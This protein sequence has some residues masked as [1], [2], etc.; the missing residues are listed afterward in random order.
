MNAHC[1]NQEQWKQSNIFYKTFSNIWNGT[2]SYLNYY[3][4]FS[5]DNLINQKDSNGYTPINL[6]TKYSMLD[7]I[8]VLSSCQLIDYLI[9]DHQ[10][11]IPLQ[12]FLKSLDSKLETQSQKVKD[13]FV[14]LSESRTA[15]TLIKTIKSHIN[16]INENGDSSLHIAAQISDPFFYNYLKKYGNLYQE[17]SEGKTPEEIFIK[18]QRQIYDE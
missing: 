12:T 11:N 7:S 5:V 8:L 9:P 10:Q 15:F 1:L 2:D 4:G 18:H 16:H 14:T 6:A 13:V 17:N 3:T